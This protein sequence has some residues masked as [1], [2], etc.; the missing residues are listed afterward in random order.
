MTR[1]T[2]TTMS[3]HEPYRVCVVCTGNICRSVMGE[4][5]LRQALEEAGLGDRVAVDSAGTTSWEEGNPADPRTVATLARQGLDGHGVR[6][7]VA[8]RFDGSWLPDLDLVLAA[9]HGHLSALRRLARR[10][11]DRAK[12]RMLRSFD[13][14]S[15]AAGD[16]DMDDPWYGGTADFERTYDEIA[17]ALPGLV[18]YVREALAGDA[19]PDLARG[20]V[21]DRDR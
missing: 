16:L 1:E 11:E 5:M 19:A 8:R 4:V 3:H 14:L 15:E 20:S 18:E 17:A 9:D 2:V 12:V 6:D 13:P 7:H 10:E 21:P